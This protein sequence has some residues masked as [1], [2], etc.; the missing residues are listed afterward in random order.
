M[1]SNT[2]LGSGSQVDA[3]MISL[4]SPVVIISPPR[5]TNTFLHLQKN[6]SNF[7]SSPESK[8]ENICHEM[9]CGSHVIVSSMDLMGASLGDIMCIMDTEFLRDTYLGT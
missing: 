8:P 7:V 9:G 6:S 2:Y 1:R 5:D 3:G 4:F